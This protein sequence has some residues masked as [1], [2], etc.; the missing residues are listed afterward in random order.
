[1][2]SLDT[3]TKNKFKKIDTTPSN[4]NFKAELLNR[5]TLAYS[6]NGG[7]VSLLS[8]FIVKRR[9]TDNLFAPSSISL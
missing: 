9:K 7:F 2:S 6:F 8:V 5:E 4:L 3:Q 1:M